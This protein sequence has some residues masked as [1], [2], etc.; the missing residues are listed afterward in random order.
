MVQLTNEGMLRW[1]EEEFE[2]KSRRER[3]IDVEGD[4]DAYVFWLA[5]IEKKELTFVKVER[6]GVAGEQQ[7]GGGNWG[8][9]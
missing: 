5:W 7:R 1:R 2:R 9:R 8:V 4:G 3:A 6:K